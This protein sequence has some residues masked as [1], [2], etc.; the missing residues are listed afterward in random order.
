MNDLSNVKK[1]YISYINNVIRNKKISHAYLIELDNY[2]CD[3][4][5]VYNF[6][7]MILCNLEYDD[8]DKSN[9]KIIKLIDDGNYPDITV[10]STDNT[11][12]KKTDILDLQ[13]EFSNKSLYDNKK[14]YIIYSAEKLNNYSANTILK[15][16]EEPEDNIIAFLLTD[17]RFNIL[18]TIISR[19]QIL[20]L[21][22]ESY[23]YQLNNDTLDFLDYLLN[24]NNFFINYNDLVK[25]KYSDKFIMKDILIESENIIIS[26]LSKSDD[27]LNDIFGNVLSDEL[28]RIVS[29]IEAYLAQLKYNVNY[30]LWLNSFFS[31]LLGG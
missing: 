29:V 21:K 23:K 19:C 8:L 18:E 20:S 24:P 14:I 28:I 31:S 7:K 5:Y 4:V 12:I 1:M 2:E 9:N 26:Y 25:N 16:L 11:V 3:I 10:I 15:F 17:N 13:K 22:E 6:I 30:K 27:R